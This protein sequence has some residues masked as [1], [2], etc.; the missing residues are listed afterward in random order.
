MALGGSEGCGCCH[1][2]APCACSAAAAEGPKRLKATAPAAASP[3]DDLPDDLLIC[4]LGAVSERATCPADLSNAML[5]CRRAAIRGMHGE[6]LARAAPA[7][8]PLDASRW[9]EGGHQFLRKCAEAGN[10]E[11]CYTLGMI[12]F[13]CLQDRRGGASLMARAAM[14]GH[15]QALHSLSIIHFNGSGGTRA[16]RDLAS[17]VILC[18]KAAALGH[19]QALRELGHCLQDGYGLAKN[20]AE[21]RRLLLEAN[22]REAA[23]LMASMAV[24][25]PPSG[26]PSGAPPA[27]AAPAEMAEDEANAAAPAAA[28]ATAFPACGAA[29]AGGESSRSTPSGACCCEVLPAGRQRS[30][31]LGGGLAPGAGNGDAS[32]AATSADAAATSA[33]ADADA[34]VKAEEAVIGGPPPPPTP[35]RPRAVAAPLQGAAAGAL[36]AGAWGGPVVVALV[37]AAAGVPAAAAPLPM[38]PREACCA[39]FGV[40]VKC[41]C[42][43]PPPG[44]PLLL[45][46]AAEALPQN[47]FLAIWHA[48]RGVSEAGLRVCSNAL[49]GRPETRA[50]EF[51]CCSACGRAKYCSRACQ[52]QDWKA[53][54]KG[55]CPLLGADPNHD[56]EN[57]AA[58]AAAAAAAAA[59]GN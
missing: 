48:L 35:T 44:A 52:A 36:P 43:P 59:G 31:G 23:Q 42:L 25:W 39:V 10:I 14:A 17:G 56:E 29:C 24:A 9:S 8:F 41:Q 16:D 19:V 57:A 7:A 34:D 45:G 27:A 55:L 4:I 50:Q 5:T 15:A 54:H 51:R 6:V 12:K 3:F 49:C 2:A 13:Y 58:P 22:A 1:L 11:A 21:G 26:A 47:R 37:A 53:G 20:V 28:A 30:D 32:L 38:P 33:D 40:G 18:A 46:G